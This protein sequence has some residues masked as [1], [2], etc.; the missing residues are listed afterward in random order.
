MKFVSYDADQEE[1]DCGMCDHIADGFDCSGS[2][3][4]EHGWYRYQR[5]VRIKDNEE[6]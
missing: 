5:T 3:G 4:P 1:P 2:C 6:E